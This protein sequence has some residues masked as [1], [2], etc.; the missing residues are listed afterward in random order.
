LPSAEAG[1]CRG[2]AIITVP[3][4]NQVRRFK[5]RLWFNEVF[6]L[7]RAIA[8]RVLRGTSMHL[9]RLDATPYVVYPTYGPFYEYRLTSDQLLAA[10][11]GAGFEVLVHQPVAH[12]DGVY[13]ELNPFGL[14][15]GF[16]DWR[17]SATPLARALNAS[18]SKRP[19]L[20]SH[21]QAVVA[22]KPQ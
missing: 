14:L 7:P 9:N 22:R 15:V 11:R 16:S 3:L 6:D 17:F 4:H 13:H 20:H 8:R 18:L 10:V 12:M 21:M 19:F 1:W 2:V 5:R